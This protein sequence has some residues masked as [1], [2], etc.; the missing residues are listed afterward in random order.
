MQGAGLSRPTSPRQTQPE[1]G[2]E[3]D[4]NRQHPYASRVVASES[5][6]PL[7]PWWESA[8]PGSLG[9]GTYALVIGVSRYDNLPPLGDSEAPPW[10]MGMSQLE[11]AALSAAG[12]AEWL[13][14]THF[15]PDAPLSAVWL[16]LSPSDAEYARL[17]P[18]K[19]RAPLA[20]AANVLN[21]ATAW[22]AACRSNAGNVG[23][24]YA[25]GHG[26]GVDRDKPGILLLQ[27]FANDPVDALLENT[28][29]LTRVHGNL[30]GSQGGSPRRQ[31]SFFD[32]CRPRSTLTLTSDLAESP[33]LWTIPVVPTAQASPM[34]L[35]A[36]VGTVAY[37][38][39]GEGTLFWQ[40]LR[41]CLESDAVDLLDDGSWGVTDDRLYAALSRRLR[42]L[43]AAVG[44]DQQAAVIPTSGGVALHVNKSP[45]SCEKS[46]AVRPSKAG[47]YSFATLRHSVREPPVFSGVALESPYSHVVSAG[48]YELEVMID[49]SQPEFEDTRTWEFLRP[50]GPRDIVADVGAV[51]PSETRV[52]A[53][54]E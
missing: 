2:L 26:L 4:W 54:V 28:L 10:S 29:N 17:A 36:A 7:A 18:D 21:A 25:A 47:S 46:F 24:L 3:L 13:M 6:V 40:A 30:A 45:P 16:L 48:T 52:E 15:L 14:T 42:E 50:R 11:S 19:R 38:V 8:G 27:D 35:G 39:P 37:G 34:F 43:A 41:T 5:G 1:S 44:R 53:A 33:P 51:I 32:A 9:P 23:L 31:F 49:P 20:L 22:R 12:F